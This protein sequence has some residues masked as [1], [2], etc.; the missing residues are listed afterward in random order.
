MSFR[1]AHMQ[2]CMLAHGPTKVQSWIIYVSDTLMVI[3]YVPSAAQA[4]QS[5]KA[6][7]A[8]SSSLG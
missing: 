6:Q 7:A 1:L 8:G 2:D 3:D 5:L 4:Q